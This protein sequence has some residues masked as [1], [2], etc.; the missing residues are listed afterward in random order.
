MRDLFDPPPM[1][2]SDPG[3]AVPLGEDAERAYLE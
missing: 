3:D 2:E 1:T